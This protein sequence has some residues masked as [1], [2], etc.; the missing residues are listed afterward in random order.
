VAE[1][2][3][4]YAVNCGASSKYYS[5]LEKITYQQDKGYSSGIASDHGNTFSPFPR[6]QDDFVYRTERYDTGSFSYTVPIKTDGE[7]VIVLKF[8][9][10]WFQSPGEKVFHVEVGGSREVK[11]LDIFGK[12]GRGVPHDEYVEVSRK[13]DELTVE[14][15]KA[16]P[17]AWNPST[18]G[19]RIDFLQIPGKDN[20]KINA[21]VVYDG[22]LD[23]I[24]TLPPYD[25]KAAAKSRYEE[26]TY[27]DDE[28][29]EE[30]DDGGSLD[31]IDLDDHQD[32]VQ[33]GL[34]E[35]ASSQ[36][37]EG[38]RSSGIF[39]L[40]FSQAGMFLVALLVIAGGLLYVVTVMA[41][42][43]TASKPEK[44]KGK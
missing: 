43:K 2:K 20:P 17:E 13:G 24:P 15:T 41:D 33:Q 12:V 31:D 25:R 21:I 1:G 39:S 42:T 18:G 4:V 14:G 10:V 28:E 7:Y 8:S 32:V 37:L 5:E 16:T 35:L 26:D 44:K 30:D 34:D 11:S 40:I 27:E 23:D 38:E 19:L 29:E 6:V 3:V 9:E 36:L 22:T